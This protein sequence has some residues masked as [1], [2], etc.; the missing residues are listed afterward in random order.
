VERFAWVTPTQMMDGLGLAEST[1]G[2]LILVLQ[3]VGFLAAYHAAGNDAAL[4]AGVVGAVLT[5]WVTF[6][7][8]F[9]W[10]FLG[11]PWSEARRGNVA[12][13]S[14]LAAITAAVVGVIAN[15]ALWFATHV[16]FAQQGPHGLPDL[17]SLRPVPAVLTAAAL[18]MLFVLRWNLARTLTVSAVL[19]ATSILL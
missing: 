11:A 7:P 9:L 5:V 10:I 17:T 16:L 3:F 14:A 18:T 1:P 8:C 13:A 15:L 4:F 2:P 6:V 19:G 12:L